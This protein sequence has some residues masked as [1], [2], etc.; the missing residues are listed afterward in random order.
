MKKII[1]AMIS[2]SIIF[3]IGI[4]IYAGR[5]NS[6]KWFMEIATIVF[7]LWACVPYLMILIANKYLRSKK[8]INIPLFI[9]TCIIAFLS[10]AAYIEAF[11]VHID[12]QAGLVFLFL[13]VPQIAIA[14]ISI[15]V[16]IILSNII[17]PDNK[18]FQS[19]P[20]RRD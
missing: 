20:E 10:F 11:F 4:M 1:N 12:P 9:G 3:T 15:L 7:M 18:T 19:T 5:P 17:K 14:C 6:I 13:P 16:S 2:I 8:T